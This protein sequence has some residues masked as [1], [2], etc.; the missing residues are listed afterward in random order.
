MIYATV[1]MTVGDYESTCDQKIVLYR[2]DKNVEIRFV[3]KSNRFTVLDST[4]AQLIITRPSSSS[5]FSELSAIQNDTVILVVTKE[6]IDELNEIGEHTFQIRLYDDTMNARVTLPPCDGGIIINEPI[7]IEGESLINAAMI[8][9]SAVLASETDE[10]TFDENNS[11][12]KTEWMDGDII[13]DARM[14]KIEN[15]LWTNTNDILGLE[16]NYATKDELEEAIKGVDVTDQLQDYA[17]TDYVNQEIQTIEL[18]PGPQGPQG[19]QGI[20]GEQGPKGDK[21]DKGDTGATGPQGPKGDKGDTGDSVSVAVSPTEPTDSN[22]VVWIDEDDEEIELL[23]TDDLEEVADYIATKVPY[24]KTAEHPICVNS[25]DEMTDTTKMYVLNSTGTFYAYKKKEI[26]TEGVIIPNFTNVL[27]TEGSRIL[28]GKRYSLSSKA[29]V[30]FQSNIQGVA[31]VIPIPKGQLTIRIRNH[32]YIGYVY[33]YLGET[34]DHF[35]V[36]ADGM[37]ESGDGFNSVD[38]EIELYY[39]NTNY[40]YGTFCAKEGYVEIITINEEITYT[41]V[42]G[43]TETTY[44]WE[45]TGISY[46]QPADYEDRV[47]LLE[48]KTVEL[49]EETQILADKIN[50]ISFDDDNSTSDKMSSVDVVFSIPA[51]P[52]VPQ[53]PA[54]GS[55]G[56][57]FNV[58]TMTTQKAYEYMEALCD[59]HTQYITKQTMGEDASGTYDHNRY[60]LTMSYWRAWQKENY[61]KMYAWKNGN[62][63]VYSVSVSPR[64]GDNMFSTKY[65]G[66]DYGEVTSVNIAAGILST[67]T[68]NGLIFTRYEEGDVEPTV[69]YTAPP[70]YPG[71]FINQVVYDS[72]FSSITRVSNDEKSYF[73]GTDGITY[74]RYPFE[75]RKKDKSKP[76]SIF[77]L[78]NEHGYKGDDLIPSLTVMRLAKDLCKNTENPFLKWMKENC[79]ITMIPVGTPW[80]YA[81]YLENGGSGYYNF[82]GVNINRNYDTPGWANSDTNYGDTE[83]FGAYPGCEN[84]TQHIMNTMRLCQPKVGISCHSPGFGSEFR[85]MADNAYFIHQGMGYKHERITKIAEV[86][87]SNYGMGCSGSNQYDMAQHYNNCGKSP[88]YIQYTGAVGGL[89]EIVPQENNTNNTHTSIAMEQ[90]YAQILLFLQTWCQE[91]LE[92]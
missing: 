55:E 25:V 83:T 80:G 59:K 72:S 61:P 22:A 82:N 69:V 11:Y 92:K 26:T 44:A 6:M 21:G 35:T 15:A 9:Y 63:I 75:D 7:A 34:N 8:N 4:Y 50:N 91:A 74:T 81:R 67:R 68:V 38:E 36:N 5:I 54:D 29:W 89:I 27:D 16:E 85:D 70:A 47:V 58:N 84:E 64:V 32:C 17:T 37:T 42:E 45:D 52:P 40:N 56:S 86:L 13:T 39:N 14:N 53:L 62:T 3:I 77:I 66:T 76:F 73:V 60:I 57:D 90:S 79:M 65:I 88:A 23:T 78:S 31:Y 19:I 1:N 10:E 30:D 12:N 49:E 87:Y 51:Y 28:P 20:Q 24:V 41:T 2:G 43:G 48:N 33:F 46:N 18:T 71:A